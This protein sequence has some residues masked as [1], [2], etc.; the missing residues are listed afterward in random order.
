MRSHGAR[1]DLVRMSL[2]L[3]AF[4]ASSC[5]RQAG[6]T[7]YPVTGTVTFKGAAVEGAVVVFVPGAEDQT[8][9]AAQAV[10]D[11]AGRFVVR[12]Y[13]AKDRYTDGMEPG[14]YAVTIAKLETVPDMTRRPK[15]LL[16]VK[17]SSVATSKLSASVKTSGENDFTFTLD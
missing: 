5:S 6:P 4:L 15:N 2:L 11:G 10:T 13:V 7:T 9:R 8:A 16:P 12:T 1:G 3:L 14:N 17:Y